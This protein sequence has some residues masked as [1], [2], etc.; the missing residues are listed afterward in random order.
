[1]CRPYLREQLRTWTG[2]ELLVCSDAGA[3]SNLV[4][5][6]HYF[7]THEEATAAALRAGVDSFTDHGTDSSVIVA[8]IKGALEQ[9]PVDRG[10]RRHGGPA[11]ALRAVPARRVR[12]RAGPVR[13]VSGPSTPPEHRALAQETAEQAVVLLKNDGLLPARPRAARDRRGRAARRRVQARL[14]QRQP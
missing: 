8:R 6:E 3:P 10:G 11:A 4:D 13:R 1:M 5:S 12:P 14:V 2:E 9:G 7:A